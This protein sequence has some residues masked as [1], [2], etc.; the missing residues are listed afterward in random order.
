MLKTCSLSI[1][2]ISKYKLKKKD[3]DIMFKLIFKTNL[4][5]TFNL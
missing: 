5:N 4:T 3:N 1:D 2:I